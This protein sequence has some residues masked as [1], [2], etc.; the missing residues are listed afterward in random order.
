MRDREGTRQRACDG[1]T[2]HGSSWQQVVKEATYLYR[3]ESNDHG[4]FVAMGHSHGID[5]PLRHDSRCR[6]DETTTTTA[7]AVEQQHNKK[8]LQALQRG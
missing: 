8:H 6:W 3:Y 7:H 1:G 4:A 2:S 5:L